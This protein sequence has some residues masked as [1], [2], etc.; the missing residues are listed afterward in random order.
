MSKEISGEYCVEY[1][2]MYNNFYTVQTGLN[3]KL[4]WNDNSANHTTT[5]PPGIYSTSGSNSIATQIGTSMTA[6]TS[7]GATIT[8]AFNP[9]NGKLTITSNQNFLLKFGTSTVN[10]I[11]KTL[12]YAAAD[13]TAATTA[14]ASNLPNL[15][16]PLFVNIRIA[17]SDTTTWMNG[18]GQ[19]GNILLSMDVSQGALKSYNR[20]TEAPQYIGFSRP[21]ASLNIILTDT[22]GNNISLNG[23]EWEA[24]I[25]KIPRRY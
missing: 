20:G 15:G 2:Q 7:A 18:L 16:G 4:Y 12:G 17:E 8:A 14:I 19:Y 22:S 1:I 6:D 21:V 25:R 5:I 13:T 11:A 3:D 9:I 24:A 23:S 10:S